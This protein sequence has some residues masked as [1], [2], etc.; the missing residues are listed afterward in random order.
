[1]V[2]AVNAVGY[3]AEATANAILGMVATEPLNFTANAGNGH[4]YL[5]WATPTNVG[6]S[7]TRYEVSSDNGAN[8]VT[9]SNSTSYTFTG[10][11]N[12]TSYTFKV[13]AVN[14]AGEGAEATTTATPMPKYTVT[15]S[16]LG[17]NGTLSATVDGSHIATGTTVEHGK[18]VI[19]TAVPNNNYQIK[20]WTLN[21]TVVTGNSTNTYTLANIS[22]AATVTVS[23]ERATNSAEIPDTPIAIV[24]PNPTD[25][26]FTLEFDTD[27]VYNLTLTD[28]SGKVLF[29]ETVS[30]QS[31]QIDITNYFAGVYLL[32]INNGKGQTTKRIVKE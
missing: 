31:V 20:E 15:F 23:F 7:I 28:M 19:F 3:G 12:G 1:M 17:S 27:G 26:L 21:G 30:G 9:A 18:S 11:T 22:A 10:L 29:Y 14:I 4:V 32:K 25:G 5:S 13:R 24:Y 8:W 16:V 6:C 2:R